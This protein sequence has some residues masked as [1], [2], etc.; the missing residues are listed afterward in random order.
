MISADPRFNQI[1]GPLNSLIDFASIAVWYLERSEGVLVSYYGPL[2]HTSVLTINFDIDESPI[3]NRAY[4]ERKPVLVEDAFGNTP[5]AKAFRHSQDDVPG[6]PFNYVKS[7]MIFPVRVAADFSIILTL[8]H[9]NRGAYSQDDLIKAD[10]YFKSVTPSIETY[11]LIKILE[12]RTNRIQAFQDIQQAISRHLKI[13]EIL[14]LIA[15]HAKSMIFAH[16]VFIFLAEGNCLSKFYATDD[17]THLHQEFD[18]LPIEG[19]LIGK[20]V[21]TNQTLRTNLFLSDQEAHPAEAALLTGQSCLL[22]PLQLQGQPIGAILASGRCFGYFGIED[23]RNLISLRDSAAVALENAQA[24]SIEQEKRRNSEVIQTIQAKI[25]P[26][27]PVKEALEGLLAEA[28]H[29]LRADAAVINIKKTDTQETDLTISY[30]ADQ[31]LQEII[32]QTFS[33]R[34]CLT[35]TNKTGVSVPSVA[36]FPTNRLYTT[37]PLPPPDGDE[38]RWLNEIGRKPVDSTPLYDEDALAGKIMT[39]LCISLALEKNY[40]GGLF[41]FWRAP[42]LLYPENLQQAELICK[43]IQMVIERN[44]LELKTQELARVQERQRIAQ[45]LHDTVAQFLFR[46][47]LE[48]HWCVDNLSTDPVGKERLQTIQHLGEKCDQE[49]RSAI[50]ALRNNFPGG[51]NNY[52]DLLKNQIIEF[53]NEYQIETTFIVAQEIQPLPFPVVET[54]YRILRES[55]TNIRK[56]ANARSVLVSLKDDKDSV[57]FIIQDDGTGMPQTPSSAGVDSRLHFGVEEIKSMVAVLGGECFIGNNDDNGAMIKVKI[58]L[59]ELLP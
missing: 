52:V 51:Q 37:S 10:A 9:L 57:I 8:S 26:E 30:S 13:R 41:F 7:V 25:S 48:A 4:Q 56:H 15:N 23:E 1:F 44:Q 6:D 5:L 27:K 53:Q 59:K 22:V 31:E 50:F 12:R 42:T 36:S 21:K 29:L 38:T 3:L 40:Q 19:S 24:Y 33:L 46:I 11:V 49:L 39:R 35:D 34:S 43:Y 32:S 55:L 45:A 2:A 14:S 20:V 18:L 16:T 54:L 47:N 17:S 58:P 28:I